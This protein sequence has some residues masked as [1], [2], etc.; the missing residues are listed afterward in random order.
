MLKYWHIFRDENKIIYV[1]L[2]LTFFVFYNFDRIKR[3][4]KSKI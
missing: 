3:E 1:L 4:E 2:F